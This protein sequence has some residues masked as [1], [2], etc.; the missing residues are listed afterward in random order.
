MSYRTVLYTIY[1]ILAGETL[2]CIHT[3]LVVLLY[4]S[5]SYPQCIKLYWIYSCARDKCRSCNMLLE[6]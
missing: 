2:A 1:T 6:M 5:S 4:V 3:I